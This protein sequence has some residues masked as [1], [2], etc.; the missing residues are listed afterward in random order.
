MQILAN[1][2]NMNGKHIKN[3]M[4]AFVP[5]HTILSLP[6]ASW[7]CHIVPVSDLRVSDTI[8]AR[9]LKFDKKHP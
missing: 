6:L 7:S 1:Y 4:Y 3:V 5:Y 2:V 9:T 8:D